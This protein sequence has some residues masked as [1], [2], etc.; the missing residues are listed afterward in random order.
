V[1]GGDDGTW[2]AVD[3]ATEP[4]AA[5]TLATPLVPYLAERA[6][7][8]RRL[9]RALA[10]AGEPDAA[11]WCIEQ[12]PIAIDSA[13]T[14]DDADRRFL[15]VV[16]G[17]VP[18]GVAAA[19]ALAPHLAAGDLPASLGIPTQDLGGVSAVCRA[20]LASLVRRTASIGAWHGSEL[21]HRFALRAGALRLEATDHR[22][23]AIAWHD[24]DAVPDDA[25]AALAVVPAAG[26]PTRARYRG[27]PARRYWEME[28]AAVF[29]PRI[30]AGPGDAGR[31]LLVEFAH[32]YSDH[33]LS[34]PIVLPAGALARVA[35]LVVTD[36][37][38]ERTLVR[39]ATELDGAGG[40]WRF[41][42]VVPR[43]GAPAG[44][45]FSPPVAGDLVGAPLAAVELV[46]DDTSNVVWAIDRVRRGLDGR[47]RAVTLPPP[48]SP[49]PRPA[50]APALAY[51]LGPAVP[52]P[53]HPYRTVVR[54]E[55]VALVRAIA[56]GQPATPHRPDL[57]EH[58]APGALALAALRV[59]SADHVARAPDGAYHVYTELTTRFATAGAAPVL[60]FDQLEE[61]DA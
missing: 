31:V 45:V 25:A 33:W 26:I 13:A 42:E 27:M 53:F 8:G 24:V 34:I 54:P 57:P 17:R 52:D 22:G 14:G 16:G 39:A 47:P 44:I 56:P 59:V 43:A 48:P 32:A 7:T 30:E 37:F 50:D 58:L 51:R 11:R 21:R 5:A 10:A 15:A 55:G 1:R 4:V 19:D 61:R 3:P 20:W 40:P 23:G 18:D 49:A 6:R 38:G 28:D 9:V 2:V 46:R 60:A 41:C 36:T 12:F 29:W 35:T